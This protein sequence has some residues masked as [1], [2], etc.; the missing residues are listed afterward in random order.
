MKSSPVFNNKENRKGD[1][2]IDKQ[3]FLKTADQY[4]NIPLEGL[5]EESVFR[6]EGK[7]VNGGPLAVFTGKHTGRSANDK[8]VVKEPSSQEKVWWGK[9]NVETSE[10]VFDNLLSKMQKYLADK[11]V[12]VKDCFAGAHP[13]SRLNVRVITAYAWQ[14]IFADN[15]FIKPKTEE[16][17]NFVPGFTVLALPNFKADPKVDGTKSDTFIILNFAKKMVLIGGS[18]YGGEIKKSIFTVMNYLLPLN[19]IL[20]MHCSANIG[21]KKDV[22]LFFGLSGTGKTSL[23]ADTSRGLIGDDEHGWNAEGVFNFEGGCYAKVIKLSKKAEP[24]IYECTRKFGTVLENV[25]YDENTRELDLNDDSVTVNTRAA[26]SLDCIENA[27][28]EKCGGHPKNIIM[29]TCD[30]YGVMP[31]IAKLTPAQALYHFISG[32]TAKVSGTELGMK[33]EIESTFSTCFGA[34]FMVHHPSVYAELL[35]ENIKK[36]KATCW[37]VNT[38]W[39]GGPFGVGSRI[40]IAYTRALLNSALE[41]KL[42]NVECYKDPVFGFEVPTKCEGVPSELLKPEN[43]WKDKQEYMETYKCLA[44]LFVKNFEKFKDG[45]NEDVILAGPKIL[46]K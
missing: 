6:G 30:A 28:P 9:V 37:L 13:A 38:G 32:Y 27:V 19:K 20:T 45:C 3:G 4:W 35:R 26:Y 8:F 5:V 24:Q 11:D 46:V 42:D 21:K 33:K 34:P 12:F 18:A 23:S 15:L 39:T 16:L 25:V 14:S 10:K 41:G 44:E 17:K 36:H 22:A 31:P 40:S 43:T 1:Y 2:G 7:L 29:L